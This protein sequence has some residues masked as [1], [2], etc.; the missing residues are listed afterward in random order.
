MVASA[1]QGK[2]K[3]DNKEPSREAQKKGDKIRL[4]TDLVSV[5]VSVTDS[6]GRMVTGLEKENF[7]I[8]DDNLEQEIA[9]FS[10]EDSPITLG[11]IYD[12][13]GSMNDLTSRS[14]QAL[15]R[16]FETSHEDDEYFIIAFN[17]KPRLVQDFTISPDDILN[18]VIFVKAGG[19]TALYDA[20]Y[21]AVEKVRQGRHKKKALLIISDGVENNSRYSLKEISTQLKESDA[22]IFTIG[23]S[24]EGEGVHTLKTLASLSGG[25]AFFPFDDNEFGDLY[26]RL[27]LMLR[28]Q[29][30]LGFYPTDSESGSR[31]HKLRV[32]MQVP[33]LLGR[34]SLY[35]RKGYQS[36]R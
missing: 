23:L 32:K 24:R 7:K 11:V 6:A 26:V 25:K 34:L 9:F 27:A 18:R 31:W 16:F 1:Q 19:N 33:R 10:N 4:S 30:V 15:R 5:T 35:Y 8:Y 13:S 3:S 12:I 2:D 36:F 28:H 22:Q 20:T 21:L 14:F 29:Y 17:S